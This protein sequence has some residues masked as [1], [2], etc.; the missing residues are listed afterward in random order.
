MNLNV[1]KTTVVSTEEKVNIFS[2]DEDTS[3]VTNCMCLAV[4]TNGEIKKR[5][6]L[7]KAAIANLAY[8]IRNLEV[9]TNTKLHYCRQQS[10]QQCRMGAEESR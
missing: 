5:I 4:I 9:A 6:S 2:D 8:I 10:F 3:K 1:K 7:S